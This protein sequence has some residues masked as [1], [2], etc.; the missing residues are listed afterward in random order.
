VSYSIPT[1]FV[2]AGVL[3][4]A[5]AA[6]VAA[7]DATGQART[8]KPAT[9]PRWDAGFSLGLLNLTDTESRNTWGTWHQKAE[10]RADVGYYW[11]THLKTDVAVSATNGWTEYDLVRVAVPGVPN[12]TAYDDFERRLVMVAPAV[13]WQFRENTFMH[14]YVSG[15]VRIG[16]LNEHQV[17]ESGTYRSGGISY[18]VAGFDQR[19]TDVLVRPFVAGGFKSYVSRSV[20]ARTEARLAF[21]QD[22]VRQVSVVA[23]IGVDF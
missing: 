12:A 9:F 6:P 3:A 8:L 17:R 15:G 19:R 21:A 4:G 22:G 1:V 13:T 14:P 10:Y 18:T 11:T 7:Q 5:L 20:F 2:L 23:G 16:L